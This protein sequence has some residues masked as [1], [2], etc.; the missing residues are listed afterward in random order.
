MELIL[1]VIAKSADH[2]CTCRDPYTKY[3]PK[4]MHVLYAVAQDSSDI[5]IPLLSFLLREEVSSGH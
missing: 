1:C 4:V 2:A 5:Y 3:Q